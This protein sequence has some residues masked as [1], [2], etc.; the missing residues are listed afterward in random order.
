MRM[1]V[2]HSIAVMM[3]KLLDCRPGA[4]ESRGSLQHVSVNGCVM[5]DIVQ[6]KRMK[7]RKY[8]KVP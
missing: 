6:S 5:L 3:N 1:V 2:A 7:P 8:L 4:Q